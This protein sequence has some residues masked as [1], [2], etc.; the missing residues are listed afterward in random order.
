M[1]KSISFIS[2]NY[3]GLAQTCDFIKSVQANVHSCAYEIIIVDNGSVNDEAAALKLRFPDIKT[4]RSEVNLGFAGGNNL[5]L[6]AAVGDYL[7]FINNDTEIL[8]DHLDLL[9]KALEEHPEA[10]MVCPKICFFSDKS[11][12]QYA[13]YTPMKGF[14][15]KNEM[16]GYGKKD[17]GTFDKAGFTAFPHGAAMLVRREALRDAG[18]MPQMYFLYYEE[19]DWA[20]MFSR[21]GWKVYFEPSCTIYHKDSLTTRRHGPVFTYYMTR[22]RLIFARRNLEG[23]QRKLSILFTRYIASAKCF[24]VNLL[25]GRLDSAAAVLRANRDFIRMNKEGKI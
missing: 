21:K 16:L 19:L 2:V 8:E 6:D 18:P 10:G 1:N 14:R 9:C 23:S 4:I 22:S 13:G 5:A 11:I 24:I 25:H 7:F 17:D 20:L 3:N 15:M 12:I